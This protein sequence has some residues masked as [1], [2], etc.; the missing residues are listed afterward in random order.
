LKY[1]I[2]KNHP[3]EPDPLAISLQSNDKFTETGVP[4][5]ELIDTN[6]SDLF[7]EYML[8]LLRLHHIRPDSLEKLRAKIKLSN[9]S[10]I[11]LQ[12]SPYPRNPNTRK[13]NFAE[14]FLAEY[15]KLTTDTK[16]PVYRLRFNPNKEESMKG[17]DVLLF[18]LDSTPVRIIVG[19]AKF[20]ET[21]SKEAVIE[22]VE[23]LVR[24]N[25]LFI[26][27]SL[28]FVANRLFDEGYKELSEKVHNCS[29]MFSSDQLEIDYVGLLMS[30]MNANKHINRHT[31]NELHNLLMISLGMINPEQIIE[32]SFNQL[33]TEL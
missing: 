11:P 17:D 3:N 4:H 13:C 32:K 14:I 7:H 9:I 16:L 25:K 19:E 5:R 12:L 24:S 33:E 31:T 21:P 20:R 15:L 2:I 30:N 28:I 1:N 27:L 6:H 23:N 29:F 10:N 22:I 8:P 26:P 18:D